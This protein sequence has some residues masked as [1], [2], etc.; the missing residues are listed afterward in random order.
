MSQRQKNQ[1]YLINKEL[2]DKCKKANLD[3]LVAQ[4]NN[5][6]VAAKKAAGE[7]EDTCK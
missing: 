3:L 6:T 2:R 5:D 7:I 4:D 1:I